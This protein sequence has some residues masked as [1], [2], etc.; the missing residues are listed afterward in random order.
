MK[1][2]L[3]FASMLALGVQQIAFSQVDAN[4]YTT[5]NMTMG[6][7]YQNRVFFDLSSNTMQSQPANTWDI[8]FYRNSS[9]NFGTR[10]NDAQNIE[11]YQ[12]SN[13][14]NDWNSITTNAVS[15]YGSPLYNLDNTA[16]IQEG[17]F[18]Q[19]TATYGWGE[20]NPGNHHIEGRVIFYPE[21]CFEQYVL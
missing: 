21:I 17:A 6:A 1:T 14:P 2:K 15:S 19:G 10:I 7:S 13:N 11:V 5:V 16:S 12:A 3:L 8:A 18:E 9:M 20:Y 4:G